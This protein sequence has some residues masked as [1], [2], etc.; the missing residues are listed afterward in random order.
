MTEA[1]WL[2]CGSSSQMLSF[3]GTRGLVTERKLRLFACGCCRLV[4]GLL[5]DRRGRIAA[6]QLEAHADELGNRQLLRDAYNTANAAF[7]EA[8]ERDRLFGPATAAAGVVVCAARVTVSAGQPVVPPTLY[9]NLAGAQ[10]GG[11]GLEVDA[12]R[13]LEADIVRDIFGDPFRVVSLSPEWRTDTAVALAQQMYESREFSAMPILAD[14]LQDAG[15]DSE[16]I[17]NH[18]RLGGVHVRGCWVIDL[19]LGKE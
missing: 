11:R 12:A 15:C 10:M 2:V 5:A 16:D 1:D 17:L 7:T 3:L 14:A 13:G 18:C 9:G 8:R 6:R 4:W 19:V